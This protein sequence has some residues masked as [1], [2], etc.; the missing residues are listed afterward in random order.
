MNKRKI[1][2]ILI[3]FIVLSC[4]KSEFRETDPATGEPVTDLTTA[5]GE[6]YLIKIA[7]KNRSSTSIDNAVEMQR[8]GASFTTDRILAYDSL[9]GKTEYNIQVRISN[10]SILLSNGQY[11]L[12]NAQTKLVNV[13]HT[14]ADPADATSDDQDYQYFYDA[15]GYLVKKLL[16]INGSATA[17]YQTDYTYT[18]G[19]LT[20][21][22]LYGGSQKIKLLESVLTY[23]TG[24]PKKPWLYLFPDFFEAY[25]YLQAFNFGK[26][27]T[28][29][30]KNITTKLFD[31]ASGDVLDSWVTNFG[32]YVI[33]KD[34]FILQ[35]TAN[36]DLQQGLGIIFGTTRFDYQCT[37]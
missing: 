3:C 35:T 31:A 23:N 20:G 12:V 9:T 24:D 27:G 22:I 11:F 6:C 30:V 7:Q 5:N 1:V 37:K 16:Y 2:S 17:F 28:A 18:A 34:G 29:L 26:K 15:Q 8:S 14:K 4:S 36:G 25:Q 32:G 33:S 13:F 21:C 10:D 19:I